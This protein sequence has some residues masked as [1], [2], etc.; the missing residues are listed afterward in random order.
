MALMAIRILSSRAPL[1]WNSRV[2]HSAFRLQKIF[3]SS[4]GSQS[5]EEAFWDIEGSLVVDP[6][7]KTMEF[8]Y[9]PETKKS[10][11]IEEDCDIIRVTRFG[12]IRLDQENQAV[13]KKDP[14]TLEESNDNSLNFIDNQFFGDK[15]SSDTAP[16]TKQNNLK[17]KASDVPV[18]TNPVDQQY[19]YPSSGETDKSKRTLPA[20]SASELEFKE[21]EVDDQYFGKKSTSSQS[22]APAAPVGKVSAYNYLRTLQAKEAESSKNSSEESAESGQSIK[23]VYEEMIPNLFK[24]P[25]EE[26]IHLLKKSVLYNKG[27]LAKLNYNFL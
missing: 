25:N 11:P 23:K 16:L 12:H 6:S 26:I 2:S 21:N 18:D 14:E 13:E 27:N 10:E 3:A 9:V 20:P 19:F 8:K 22:Q 24:M 17:A 4:Q 15:L 7:S 1:C 5:H